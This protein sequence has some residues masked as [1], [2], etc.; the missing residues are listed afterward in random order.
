M[1]T[2]EQAAATVVD[3]TP[4]GE[5]ADADP[6]AAASA[7][8][9]AQAAAATSDQSRKESSPAPAGASGAKSDP[10]EKTEP[11]AAEGEPKK[12]PVAPAVAALAKRERE[13]TKREKATKE[14]EEKHAPLREAIEKRDLGAVLKSG[15]WTMQDVVSF[16]AESDDEPAEKE[17]TPAEVAR[18]EAEKLLAERDAKAAEEEKKA[19]DQKYTDF[20]QKKRTE[21]EKRAQADTDRWELIN[22]KGAAQYASEAWEVIEK[23]HA[24]T[25]EV[26]SFDD[27]LDSIEEKL[28]AEGRDY[29]TT[30]KLGG[31][32]GTKQTSNEA[33]PSKNGRAAT[34]TISNR[35]GGSPTVSDEDVSLPHGTPP[36]KRASAVFEKL[37]AQGIL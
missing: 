7:A 17:P 10:A 2:A 31:G 19:F 22:R 16:I 8:S 11:K 26:L 27:V 30:K 36:E 1:A 14:W 20:T 6:K 5:A 23:I 21:I 25:G 9:G 15:G 18:A 28:V 3:A 24:E 29:L 32:Q 35:D 4:S 12:E 13:V 37:R 34:P 33:A